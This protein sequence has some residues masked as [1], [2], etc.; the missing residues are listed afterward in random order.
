MFVELNKSNSEV[1]IMRLN[2]PVVLTI[3]ASSRK[4]RY[5]THKKCNLEIYFAI[6]IMNDSLLSCTLGFRLAN[7]R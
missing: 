3:A 1:E 6:I 2:Y 7:G 4:N 5:E